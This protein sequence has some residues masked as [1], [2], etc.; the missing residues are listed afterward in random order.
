[1]LRPE[2]PILVVAYADDVRAVLEKGLERFCVQVMSC[3]SFHEAEALALVNTVNGLLVDLT[4]IIKAKGTEKVL[5]YTLASVYPTLRVRNTGGEP[6]PMAMPGD[7]KQDSSLND[8]VT[9]S[10]A[11]FMPRRLR[12]Y[13]RRE[14]CVST[15]RLHSGAD[16]R[17]FTLNISWGG[18]FVVDTHP[19]RFAIGQ[20]L[21]LFFQEIGL[22]VAV[23][24][25]WIQYWGQR[26][27]PGIGVSFTAIDDKLEK[28]LFQLLKH[29]REHD[30][31]L[32][33]K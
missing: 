21:Q 30:R 1:M 13:R 14:I 32:M 9:K 3:A 6:V 2:A 28:A 12:R 10:C 26:H 15:V 29:D 11:A 19:E 8:F 17:G 23:K 5:A 18:A 25:C 24:V 31:D 4:S 22:E 33:N 7:A 20:D 27:F 16:E